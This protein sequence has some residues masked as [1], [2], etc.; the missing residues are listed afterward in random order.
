MTNIQ[1]FSVR[2]KP[3]GMSLEKKLT[4]TLTNECHI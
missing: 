2:Y 4:N 1:K 3:V